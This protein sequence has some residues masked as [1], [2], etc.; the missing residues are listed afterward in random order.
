MPEITFKDHCVRCGQCAAICPTHKIYM[1]DG[2][3]TVHP[4]RNCLNCMHCAAACPTRA[5]HFAHV[6]G[7]A[8]YPDTPENETL[9]LLMSRRSVRH[10]KDETPEIDDIQWALDISQYAPSGRNM[11]RTKYVVLHGREKCDGLYNFICDLGRDTGLMPALANQRAKG[12]HDSITCGCSVIIVA[13]AP[14]SVPGPIPGTFT[15]LD[16]DAAIALSTAD[17]LL[18]HQGLGTCWGGY[19]TA[20]AAMCPEVNEYLHVPAG[21]HIVGALLVGVP[22]ETYPNVPYRPAAEIDWL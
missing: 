15:N 21:Y 18:V 10:F 12:N 6:P 3:P 19:I 16:T 1:A 17:L 7:Y 2:V 9:K 11:H 22:N 20:F 14:D 8:E 13:L 5:I 4:T